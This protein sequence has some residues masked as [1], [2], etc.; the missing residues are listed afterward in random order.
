MEIM[1]TLSQG[2]GGRARKFESL[3]LQRLSSVGQCAVAKELDTSESTISRMKKDGDIE[4]FSKLMEVLGLKVVP[5]DM[6]CFNPKDID[7]ILH[8]AKNWLRHVE[9]AEQLWEYE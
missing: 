5:A 8:Q 7:A 3:I 2:G 6:K 9:S 4:R 1:K